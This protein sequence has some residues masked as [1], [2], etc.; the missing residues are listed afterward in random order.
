MRITILQGPFLPV[1]PIMGGAIEKAWYRLGKD[2]ARQGNEVV[3]ISRL[4]DD[5]PKEETIDE[6]RHLR[7]S[8]FDSTASSLLLK[9][10]DFRYVMRVRKVLPPADVL[11]THSF[12]APL[13]LRNSAYGA[14]YV[15]VG[16]YPKGQMK[17]YTRAARLQA[18]SEAIAEAI[19]REVPANAERV[20]VIPYPLSWNPEAASTP[21]PRKKR[22]LY[23]GRIH[24]EKGLRELVKAFAT[25]PKELLQEWTL[26]VRGPYLQE[27]GGQGRG[28]LDELKNLASPVAKNVKF[29]EPAFDED[30]LR[31]DLGEASLFVYPSL[32]HRGETFG[33]AVLEAMSCGCPPL[34]SALDCFRDFV[35]EGKTGFVFDHRAGDVTSALRQK[36]MDVV[37]AR[38]LLPKVGQ[39]ARGVAGEFALEPVAMRFINDFQ[40][41]L[42]KD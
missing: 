26:H 39:D 7:V 29:L 13:L 25:L 4:F 28:F 11:V 8:G 41:V 32:A 18:P 34:V 40:G 16:R 15:H 9:L 3:H 36:I 38:V 31:N 2:F 23:L 10:R 21:V 37:R 22:L 42:L 1:P 35:D 19:R 20:V 33:L 5:L 14:I 6:V 17:L 27:Q 24:P 30:T 12:W